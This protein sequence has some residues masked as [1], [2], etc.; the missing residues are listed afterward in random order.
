MIN[1]IRAEKCTVTHRIVVL[2]HASPDIRAYS[3]F[4]LTV[5]EGIFDFII[6]TD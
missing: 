2:C 3:Q 6:L 5:M 4:W 1:I